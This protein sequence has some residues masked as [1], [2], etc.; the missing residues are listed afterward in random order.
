MTTSTQ[1]LAAPR[2]APSLLRRLRVKGER[3][4]WRRQTAWKRCAARAQRLSKHA[5]ALDAAT[6]SSQVLLPDWKSLF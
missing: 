1:S 6:S 4:V 5:L 3:S 2:L